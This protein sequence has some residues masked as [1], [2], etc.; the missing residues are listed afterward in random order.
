[1]ENLGLSTT[2]NNWARAAARCGVIKRSRS[3]CDLEVS[4]R[5][6]WFRSYGIRRG[7]RR[8]SLQN[9]GEGLSESIDEFIL[10]WNS[11]SDFEVNRGDGED[12]DQV[13]RK[14]GTRFSAIDLGVGE[15]KSLLEEQALTNGTRMKRMLNISPDTPVGSPRKYCLHKPGDFNHTG[16]KEKF[17]IFLSVQVLISKTNI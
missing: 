4:L 14:V 12:I 5:S 8:L 17:R 1:M 3:L 16:S 7:G 11:N 9:Q 6:N 13:V 2:N 10:R 15:D